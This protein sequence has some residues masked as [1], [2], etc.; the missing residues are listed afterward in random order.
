MNT[1]DNAIQIIREIT[2]NENLTYF[3]SQR[4]HAFI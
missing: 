4:V 3:P 1:K 2:I